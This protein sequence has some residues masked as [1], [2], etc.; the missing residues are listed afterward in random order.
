MVKLAI[1]GSSVLNIPFQEGF[2]VGGLLD[3]ARVET[4]ERSTITVNGAE[5][6]RDTPVPDESVVAV[7]PKIRNG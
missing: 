5:A 7:T 2:T 6:Q 4:N 1:Q 3:S